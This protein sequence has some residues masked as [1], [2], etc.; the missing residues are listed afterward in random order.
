[1][2]S[3]LY[4]TLEGIYITESRILPEGMAM[5]DGK[6]LYVQNLYKWIFSLLDW[7]EALDFACKHANSIIDKYVDRFYAP[8]K[9]D[10]AMIPDNMNVAEF[11]KEWRQSNGVLFYKTND[12]IPNRIPIIEA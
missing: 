9:I 4:K 6:Q 1:M 8:I 7:D 10:L 3:H 2:K 12:S 5:Y 11:I